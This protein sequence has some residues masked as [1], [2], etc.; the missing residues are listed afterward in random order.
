MTKVIPSQWIIDWFNWWEWDWFYQWPDNSYRAGK[1]IETRQVENALLIT[2]KLTDTW[3]T[4]TGTFWT[5][6]PFE[7]RSFST[8]D[9]SVGYLYRNWTLATV[10]STWTTAYNQ[11]LGWGKMERWADNITYNYWFTATNS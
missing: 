1:N 3:Q 6:N 2:N 5:V 9:S 7:P 8:Y 4:F 11:I 10:V